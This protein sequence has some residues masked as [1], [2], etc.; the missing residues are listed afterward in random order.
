MRGTKSN[1]R[2]V[3]LPAFRNAMTKGDDRD[4]GATGV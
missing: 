3:V 2:T 4:A 1:R